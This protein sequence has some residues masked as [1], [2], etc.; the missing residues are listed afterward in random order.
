M[1][2]E[3]KAVIVTETYY[4]IKYR[5]YEVGN[6]SERVEYDFKSALK[7]YNELYEEQV[8]GLK[9]EKHTVDKYDMDYYKKQQKL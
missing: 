3:E 5:R 4:L 2:K 6:L 7:A 1:T 8:Y 9:L